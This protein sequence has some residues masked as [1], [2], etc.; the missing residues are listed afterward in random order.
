MFR[1]SEVPYLKWEVGPGVPGVHE[2]FV[3]AGILY[4][5]R[6]ATPLGLPELPD[7]ATV[8]L[9]RDRE[10]MA[11]TLARVENRPLASARESV[12]SGQL[13]WTSGSGR[14]GFGLANGPPA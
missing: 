4:L 5:H 13:G 12:N 6:Y 1:D 8:Y 10:L 11:E 7:D 14:R 9:Y 3:R 2:G